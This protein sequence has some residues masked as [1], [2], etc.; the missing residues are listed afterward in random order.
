MDTADMTKNTT[1]QIPLVQNKE[2]TAEQLL[3]VL[4]ESRKKKRVGKGKLDEPIL[5]VNLVTYIQ[6]LIIDTYD[7]AYKLGVEQGGKTRATKARRK[8]RSKPG[9]RA[10]RSG[11]VRI[12]DKANTESI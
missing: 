8:T 9:A 2:F 6:G 3:T 5:M 11:S 10:S 12:N 7:R 4:D 1:K